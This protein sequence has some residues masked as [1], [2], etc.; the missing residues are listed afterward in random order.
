MGFKEIAGAVGST[1]GSSVISGITGGLFDKKTDAVGEASD[2]MNALYPGTTPYERLS[3]GGGGAAGAGSNEANSLRQ[4]QTQKEIANIGANTARQVAETNK[5]SAGNVANIN[6]GNVSALGFR[7]NTK[8][9]DLT[10]PFKKT[11]DWIK[12]P[13]KGSQTP[14][15][16]TPTSVGRPTETGTKGNMPWGKQT[17]YINVS[18]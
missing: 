10:N 18:K 13:F 17:D 4:Q 1:V 2:M 12:T 8:N 7:G 11:W 15:K 3:A 16:K 9:E 5:E 6:A 14:A